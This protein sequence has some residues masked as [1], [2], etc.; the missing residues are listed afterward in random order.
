M[1]LLLSVPL[2]VAQP[3]RLCPVNTAGGPSWATLTVLP[4]SDL[5]LGWTGLLHNQELAEGTSLTLCLQDCDLTTDPVCTGTGPVGGEL[6]GRF[7]GPPLPLQ[8]DASACVVNEYRSDIEVATLDLETGA[9]EMTVHLSS[10]LHQ[11]IDMNFPCPVCTPGFAVGAAGTCVGPPGTGS[12]CTVGGITPFGQTSIDCLPDPGD[13]VGTLRIDLRLSTEGAAAAG[14]TFQCLPPPLGSEGPCPCMNQ[15][16]PNDCR[17][18]CIEGACPSGLESGIDQTCCLDSGGTPRSCFPAST[19]LAREGARG[20]PYADP[21]AR[22]GAWPAP[23]YPKTT[24][25]TRVATT[26]CVPPTTDSFIN[27]VGGLAGPGAAVLPVELIVGFRDP[28]GPAEPPTLEEMLGALTA[29]LPDPGD[30]VG[31][32]RKIAKRLGR[33][34]RRIGKKIEKGMTAS[35][36]ARRRR[37][38]AAEH[39][40][41]KLLR[42][43]RKADRKNRLGVPLGPIE[44]AA[45]S[46]ATSLVGLGV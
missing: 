30:A 25:A 17:G 28:T 3:A 46:V 18:P 21:A 43:A 26:F 13:E 37:Y 38:R 24:A 15:L 32:Q 44:N 9:I 2:A 34:D 36:R 39:A 45:E 7:F 29:A 22:T 23:G 16:H 5:D 33:Y 8:G 31:K 20:V 19:N 10:T 42:T 1:A 6:N 14:D 12:P 35:D 40:L 41:E 27:L 11:G 4:G